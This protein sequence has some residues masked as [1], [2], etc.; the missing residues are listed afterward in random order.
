MTYT[1]NHPIINVTVDARILVTHQGVNKFVLIRRG[2]EPFYGKLAMPG[3]FVNPDERL[4]EAV[5]REVLEETG[6]DIGFEEYDF[7]IYADEPNRDPRGR[8]ISFV[9]SAW[10]EEEELKNAVAGDDAAAI[11]LVPV[12][13]L[14]E[15]ECAFDHYRL[16]R[17][18]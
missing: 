8:T 5:N 11:E 4:H 16:I 2:G 3:G 9:F 10:I 7:L 1:S 14:K 15:E 13:S 17:E 18:H 12:S 6:L